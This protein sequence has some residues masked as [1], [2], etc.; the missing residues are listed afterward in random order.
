[1][2]AAKPKYELLARNSLGAREETNSSLAISNGDVFI[3]TFKHLWCIGA[4]APR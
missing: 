2:F 1:V 4:D 3:R